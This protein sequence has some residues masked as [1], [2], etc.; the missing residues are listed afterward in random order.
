MR[1]RSGAFRADPEESPENVA[2]ILEKEQSKRD[3]EARAESQLAK[4]KQREEEA[5][6]EAEIAELE[7][8]EEEELAAREHEAAAAAAVAAAAA[9]S[10]S[11]SSSSSS[12]AAEAAPSL[13]TIKKNDQSYDAYIKILLLGDTG[14]GKS[15]LMLRY[16]DNTFIPSL[17]STTGVDFKVQYVDI[18]GKRV[19]LQI[20]DT[21][22]QEKFHIITKA[23][24]RGA[25]GIALVYDVSSEKTFTN[26]DYWMNNISE[27]ASSKV[28]KVLI[29]N[30]I[31]IPEREVDLARGQACA[32][33]YNC[34]HFE[35]SA[36]TNQN[37]QDAFLALA[38]EILHN[39]G[40]GAGGGKKDDSKSQSGGGSGGK[41]RKDKKDCI[42]L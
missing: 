32:E 33:K 21:A 2:K 18:D 24:Y 41:K 4:I 37:V 17:I 13:Y 11:S 15:S 35:T 9:A 40:A 19:K 3:A 5:A 29:A 30:K 7:R 6:R 28:S 36:K 22:G 25:M 20:W 10:A 26:V 8:R 12:S 23:Y 14:V 27:N 39:Q 1:K 31:D 38:R 34:A 42:I 16:S